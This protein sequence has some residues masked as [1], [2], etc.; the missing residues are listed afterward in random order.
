MTA[1]E[2]TVA[3]VDQSDPRAQPLL[4]ELAVEYSS[5]YGGTAD[6]MYADL[7]A[8][9]AAEFAPPDGALVVIAR[10]DEVVAGGA[11]RRLDPETAELKRIWTSAAHR[12]RGLARR[13][14]VELEREIAELGYQ[15]VHLTTGWRQ[16]EAVALYLAAGYTALYDPS[17][18][19]EEIGP[20]PFEKRIGATR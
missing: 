14:L 2:L 8:Y 1:P 13:V 19:A 3:R 4:A 12:R 11:F 6:E 9:P 17:V 16:P 7:V 18:P 5:R 20:H 15:R 10:G